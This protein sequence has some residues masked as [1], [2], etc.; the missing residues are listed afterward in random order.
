MK[1]AL[2]VFL[3]GSVLPNLCLAQENGRY[4]SLKAAF[5]N[6]EVVIVLELW[7]SDNKLTELPKNISQFKNVKSIILRGNDLTTL[8]E[9]IQ[10][11]KFLEELSLGDNEHLDI[12]S[13]CII[14]SKLPNLR[15]L[16]LENTGFQSIPN[17]IGLLNKLKKLFV[18]L[19]G[20]DSNQ[21]RTLKRL[22]PRTEISE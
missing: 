20:L 9:S 18:G 8:P 11:L 22:F 15:E 14:L 19:N 4:E 1:K 13:V 16:D 7:G 12:P 3:L 6:P 21:L 17:E 10:E 5:Q 2:I